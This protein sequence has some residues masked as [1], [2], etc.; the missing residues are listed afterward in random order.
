[1]T[2]HKKT[3]EWIQLPDELSRVYI[4]DSFFVP[5]THTTHTHTHTHTE[6]E[7]ERERDEAHRHLVR[8]TTEVPKDN[9]PL[10]TLAQ[11]C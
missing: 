10:V 3:V 1:M 7:R 2:Q 11:I 8:Y 9:C 6:R 5:A 4:H